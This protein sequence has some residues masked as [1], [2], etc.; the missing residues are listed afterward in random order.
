MPIFTAS[1]PMSPT[2][3]SIC[4]THHL[5]RHRHHRLHAE[6]VLRGDRG[7]RGHRVA[8]EHGHRL[9]VGLDARAAAAVGAGDDQDARRLHSRPLALRRGGI[10]RQQMRR[11]DRPRLEIAAAIGA[12]AAERPVDAGRR[13]RCIRRCRC[14]PPRCP[15]AGRGRSARNRAAAPASGRLHR[16]ADAVDH[17][18]R[19]APRPR[20]RP[21][22]GSAARCPTCGSP[23]G[24]S[25]PSRASPAAIAALTL[26]ASS[27]APPSK[28][29]FLS[30]CG[31]GSNRWSNSLAGLSVRDQLGEHLQ[32]RDQ[33]VAGRRIVGED[34]VAGLLA[35]DIV[36][37]WRASPR[38]R[39]GRRPGCA[40][41]SSPLPARKRSRPR[42]DI[43]VATMPPPRSRPRRCQDEPISA[44][45]WSPSTDLALLVDDDQPVGVAVERDA[46]IGAA[47]RPPVAC[48]SAGVGR[49]AA[50]VDVEAVGRDAD[51][52]HLG[53]QLPQAPRARPDRR[54]RW[55]NRRRS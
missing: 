17:L 46:D 55:R 9:D 13:R 43:T 29:T 32:R 15:A 35:A 31:S 12:D 45:S 4:A 34:D 21:S 44:I 37:A 41:S 39:S 48:S 30:S 11:P 36:A 33:A 8:A 24:R 52:D 47:P 14:A 42:L 27:G 18:A 38:A 26:S 40:S 5:G 6:R 53:A 3:A 20:L 28:R 19:P 51:R 7:D 25:P 50:V 2:T 10:F 49:A 23:A 22:P 16:L 54:R 1:T